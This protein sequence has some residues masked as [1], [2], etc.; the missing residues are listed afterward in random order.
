MNKI[1][2]GYIG[3]LKANSRAIFTV[4]SAAQKALDFLRDRA[5]A[6][7]AQAAE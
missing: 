1:F 6:E 5:L 4:T 3:L 7:P 2:G